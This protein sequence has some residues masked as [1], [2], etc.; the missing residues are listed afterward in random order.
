[1]TWHIEDDVGVV[2]KGSEV[3]CIG[4]MQQLRKQAILGLPLPTRG[5]VRVVNHQGLVAATLLADLSQQRL[6][7]AN[8]QALNLIN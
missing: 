6:V 1:M 8:P 5:A 4:R 7:P 3:S 2:F